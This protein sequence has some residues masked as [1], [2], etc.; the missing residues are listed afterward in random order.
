MTILRNDRGARCC[1]DKCG[2]L[3]WQ[4]PLDTVEKLLEALTRRG[5]RFLDPD[6]QPETLCDA[7]MKSERRIA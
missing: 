3:S 5:W 6:G 2:A 7:C 1:C 4:V